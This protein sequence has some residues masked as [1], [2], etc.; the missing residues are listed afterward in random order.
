MSFFLTSTVIFAYKRLY[1][2][3]SLNHASW[4]KMHSTAQQISRRKYLIDFFV[5]NCS[6]QQFIKLFFNC[7]KIYSWIMN[8]QSVCFNP[9]FIILS[10]FPQ[11]TL[12]STSMKQQN[13]TSRN[14]TYLWNASRN[15]FTCVYIHAGHET[16]RKNT[17]ES[18]VRMKMEINEGCLLIEKA[19]QVINN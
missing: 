14:R 2:L 19:Y 5:N 10:A 8:Q 15:A 6:S 12:V 9:L 11:I 4:S 16:L 18:V 3:K 13:L 7:T 17:V 1:S